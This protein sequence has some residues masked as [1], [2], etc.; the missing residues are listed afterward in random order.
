MKAELPALRKE[1]ATIKNPKALKKAESK[2][3]PFGIPAYY[4]QSIQKYDLLKISRKLKQPI[5]VLQGER[6]YQVLM[7]D[8]EIWKKELGADPKNKF[9][10]YPSL[11]HLLMKGE[12][13][14]TPDEY[15]EP[16]NVDH[17]LI[18]DM[19]DFIKNVK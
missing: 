12:G 6:D 18:L 5:L 2:D 11:N 16:G 10:S 9:I 7:K 17:K 3:L 19:V 14:S 13:K 1:V 8:F 4:W 15:T